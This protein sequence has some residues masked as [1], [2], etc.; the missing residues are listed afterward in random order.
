[1]FE[2]LDKAELGLASIPVKE[3]GGLIWGILDRHAAADFSSL[4]AKL[5]EDLDHLRIP[6]AHVYGRQLFDVK[7]NWKLVLEPFQENY[8]VR[9]LHAASIGDNFE[10]GPG[11]I[12]R[13]GRHQRKTYGNQAFTPAALD[14]PGEDIHKLVTHIYQLF[15]NGV[16]IT[17]PYYTSLMILM[18]V[19]PDRTT[20]EYFMLTPN[21]PNSPKVEDLFARSY[22][23]IRHVFGNED[24]R[25]AEISQEGLASGALDEVIYGGMEMTIPAYYDRLDACLAD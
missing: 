5:G 17:S 9:R 11:V 10:D 7:A 16:L 24:Y 20:V 12:R 8:H 1:M 18:P 21:A 2:A 4:E 25:A 22:D 19:A 14:R 23:L 13:F 15:P 3:S 6:E